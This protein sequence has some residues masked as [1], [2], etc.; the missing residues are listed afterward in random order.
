MAEV[1]LPNMLL[2]SGVGRNSGKTSFLCEVIRRFHKKF[3]VTAIKISPHFHDPEMENVIICNSGY[4][5]SK[6][7]NPARAKDSSRFLNAGADTVYYVQAEDSSLP[8]AWEYLRNLLEPN[9]IIVCEGG[10]LRH[11]VTPG[12]FILCNFFDKTR[13]KPG[14]DKLN[15]QADILSTGDPTH[16]ISRIVLKDGLQ[17]CLTDLPT[18][19]RNN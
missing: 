3:H 12:L 1:N 16:L 5:I 11:L 13:S 8:E 4:V 7:T 18:D 6:E 9:A 14:T 19:D 15:S 10:R 2:V 17:F